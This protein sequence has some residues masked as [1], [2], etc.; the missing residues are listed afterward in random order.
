MIRL[1]LFVILCVAS[2]GCSSFPR[3]YRRATVRTVP[4]AKSIDGAWQGAWK[5][6]SGNSGGLKCILSSSAAS[7]GEYTAS[8]EAKFWGVFTAHYVVAL[9]GTRDA[10]AAHLSGDQ[11]LGGL[12]GGKYHYEAT[13]TPTRFDATFRSPADHGEFHMT[14]P[15]AVGAATT[16]S[17]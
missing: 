6:A 10:D 8:F 2:I 9:K 4:E 17:P 15:A 7:P 5:S 13:V 11:D 3:D 14:R 1:A 16:S 12:E